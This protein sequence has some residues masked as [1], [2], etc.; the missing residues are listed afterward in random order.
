MS[1]SQWEVGCRVCL[2]P[3][4]DIGVHLG[5]VHGLDELPKAFLVAVHLPVSTDEE[6]PGHVCRFL[7]ESVC[8]EWKTVS[9]THPG[10]LRLGQ[11]SGR[12]TV[13]RGIYE[14]W[15]LNPSSRPPP[16]VCGGTPANASRHLRKGKRKMSCCVQVHLFQWGQEGKKEYYGSPST[17]SIDFPK[18]TQFLKFAKH[19]MSLGVMYN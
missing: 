7:G 18:V 15:K 13:T 12:E 11:E 5:S 1:N 6:F 17:G 14:H 4:T 3:H 16:L 19:K 2:S 9:T 10:A 8:W